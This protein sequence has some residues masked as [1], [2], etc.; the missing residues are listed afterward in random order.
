MAGSSTRAGSSMA[1]WWRLRTL[2]VTPV[3]RWALFDG[4][5][6]PAV[7]RMLASVGGMVQDA[8]DSPHLPDA[9][10]GLA[11]GPRPARRWSR[12]GDAVGLEEPPR[13]RMG[14]PSATA[15]KMRRIGERR[16]RVLNVASCAPCRRTG[17]RRAG[18]SLE[19]SLPA[20]RA[21]FAS[22]LG[23]SADVD[24]FHT[25]HHARECPQIA[26]VLGF[27]NVLAS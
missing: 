1:R 15:S 25:R 7:E 26:P 11:D 5:A 16:F 8:R 2:C 20:G 12:R 21:C 9:R 14:T 3:S 10:D 23:T 18:S 13:R 22:A 4:G 19:K 24:A 27:V 17:S 6:L